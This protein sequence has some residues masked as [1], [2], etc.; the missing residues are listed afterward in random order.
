MLDVAQV[1]SLNY[2][3][4]VF[5]TGWTHLHLGEVEEAKGVLA[6][7]VL[8]YG[9]RL[10]ELPAALAALL[11]EPQ[12]ARE[13]LNALYKTSE[14]SYVWPSRFIVLHYSLGDLDEAY[15]WI[16]RGIR[17]HGGLFT[18]I[19]RTPGVFPEMKQDKRWDEAMALL[20]SME[21]R[22]E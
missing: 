18:T 11:G 13:R 15:A 12:Q 9:K 5:L 10:P 3:W 19:I 20:E 7:S 22:V 1:G 4:G 16:D 6:E 17:G 21:V 2:D 8:H 14:R